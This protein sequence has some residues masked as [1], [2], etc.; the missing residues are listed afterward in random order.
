LE[1]D[2]GYACWFFEPSRH[3]QRADRTNRRPMDWLRGEKRQW[4]RATFLFL[5]PSTCDRGADVTTTCY[6]LLS[7]SHRS[8][9]FFLSVSVRL[10]SFIA[11]PHAGW[12]ISL[13][14]TA[15]LVDHFDLTLLFYKMMLPEV[16]HLLQIKRY[17]I[18]NEVNLDKNVMNMVL[19]IWGSLYKIISKI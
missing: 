16:L 4:M 5:L 18:I 17:K 3:W 1:W 9:S 6:Y 12:V 2:G 7:A 11:P 8:C 19:K 13:F 15:S 10:I 14:W